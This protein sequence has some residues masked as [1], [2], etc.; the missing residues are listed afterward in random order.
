MERVVNRRRGLGPDQAPRRYV[1]RHERTGARELAAVRTVDDDVDEPRWCTCCQ[2][3]TTA[4]DRLLAEVTAHLGF[5]HPGFAALRPLRAPD[6][7]TPLA[8]VA[9]VPSEHLAE[10]L[11]AHLRALIADGLAVAL[12]RSA[13]TR[14][15]ARTLRLTMDQHP[16]LAAWRQA[17][18]VASGNLLAL[19]PFWLRPLDTWTPPPDAGA[20]AAG[21]A[22]V[23]H[24]LVRF[25]VP[26]CLYQPWLGGAA[27]RW[28]WVLWLVL[29]GQGAS[30][31]DAARVFGW[32]VARGLERRLAR[33][34]AE[35]DPLTALLWVEL[36]RLRVGERGRVAVLR[37]HAYALDLS[38]TG[39]GGLLDDLD[40]EPAWRADPVE[41]NR[42]FWLDTAGWLA[43]HG[44]AL[45]VP[46]LSAVLDWAMH[47]YTESLRPGGAAFHWRGRTAASALTDATDYA[48]QRR[49]PTP[50]W[51]NGV[52]ITWPR[53]RADWSLDAVEGR[54]LVRELCTG[55]ELVEESM[56]LHHCVS[57]Y[58]Y[59]CAQGASQ[60]YSLSRDD[61][62]VLTIE[63][64]AAGRV[65]QVR[66]AAN[67][68]PTARERDLVATW[69][70]ATQ[71]G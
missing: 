14:T 45:P 25:P 54:W 15:A 61:V 55:E 56:A 44:E 62:R 4:A 33:A 16:G 7:T 69:L 35:L 17:C 24:L 34:P 9:P 28:K 39:Q 11:L 19:A 41:R 68:S 37:H 64:D 27:P 5:G 59:R 29:L 60:I 66:G 3:D 50:R 65:V 71:A 38:E 31:H 26:A 22:L 30:L 6:A 43:R 48:R 8:A 52:A 13:P 67:R 18:P 51:A 20:D 53:H 32:R 42:A 63:L 21:R 1:R 23:D 47:R 2:D 36:D 12:D 40:A 10:T 70:R 57:G 46:D 49:A 58:A